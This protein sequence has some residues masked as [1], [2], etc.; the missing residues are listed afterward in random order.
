ML[1]AMAAAAVFMRLLPTSSVERNRSGLSFIRVAIRAPQDPA[2]AR[3][4]RRCG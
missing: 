3:Y 1:V 2:S 4:R